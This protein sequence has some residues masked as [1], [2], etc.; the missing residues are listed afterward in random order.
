MARTRA[1]SGCSSSIRRLADLA[2]LIAL[3]LPV[4]ALAQGQTADYRAAM[5]DALAALRLGRFDNAAVAYDRSAGLA[6]TGPERA[7]AL[8]GKGQVLWMVRRYADSLAAYRKAAEET[9]LAA[10]QRR[11]AWQGVV[12]LAGDAPDLPV[13]KAAADA[14]AAAPAADVTAADR[15][16]VLAH[17]GD[18]HF[19]A[20][21]KPSA[22]ASWRRLVDLYPAQPSARF[23]CQRLLE[24]YLAERS[25]AEHRSAEIRA[26]LDA[27][28]HAGVVYAEDLYVTA[29]EGLTQSDAAEAA[30]LGD[31]LLAWRPL[32]PLAWHVVWPAHRKLGDADAFLKRALDVAGKQPAA[33]PGLAALADVLATSM[34]PEDWSAGLALYERLLAADPQS[35]RLLYGA[36]EAA[37]RLDRLDAADRWTAAGVQLEPRE[38]ATLTLRGRVLV[39]LDRPAEAL[40]LLKQ[41]AQYQ[42]EDVLSAQRLAGMMDAAGLRDALPALVAEVR[43]ATGN[44]AA[45]ASALATSYRAAGKWREAVTELASAVNAGEASPSYAVSNLRQWLSDTTSGAEVA[46]A[47]DKLAAASAM[48]PGLAPAHLFA[49]ALLGRREDLDRRLAALDP[50][51]RGRAALQAAEWLEWTGRDDLA[52]PLYQAVLAAR[53]DPALESQIA[54]RLAGDLADQGRTN[55][56]RRLLEAHRKPAMPGQMAAPYDLALA[57]LLLDAGETAGA[58]ALL[59]PLSARPQ[60]I[61][62]REVAYLLAEAAFRRGDYDAATRRLADVAARPGASVLTPPAPPQLGDDEEPLP[63]PPMVVLP[64]PSTTLA[65]SAE[66]QFLSAEIALRRGDLDLARK[67]FLRLVQASPSSPQ[68]TQAVAWMSLVG[69]LQS[70][71][72]PDRTRALDGLRALDAGKPDRAH[73]LWSEWIDDSASPLCGNLRLLLAE[74]LAATDPRAAAAGLEELVAALPDS[75]LGPYALYRAAELR[76]ASEPAAAMRLARSVGEKYPDSALVPLAS[77]LADEL[78]LR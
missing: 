42:P 2:V 19:A 43:A 9:G 15:A 45:L 35:G 44:K 27:A 75:P 10:Y 5:Q 78:S 69:A 3:A 77:R 20:G 23:A 14:L 40:A 50:A 76:A 46:A 11:A 52:A 17:L 60:G 6:K 4:G 68:A 38:P 54:L 25:S 71:P 41:A 73:D 13:A 29:I 33:G 51:D 65:M 7:D 18:L 39:R 57:R 26:L 24:V 61:D 34:A 22:L 49:L 66:P 62:P 1:S 70:L 67:A 58:E 37:L 74:A 64:P 59:Q 63:A 48:P 55:E 28:R 12:R 47:L 72:V 32:S 56:A 31:D 8:M 30:K 36:G 53:I 21:D 16:S